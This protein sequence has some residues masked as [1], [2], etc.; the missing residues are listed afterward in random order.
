[1]G[2]SF[3]PWQSQLGLLSRHRLTW[4]QAPPL[5]TASAYPASFRPASAVAALSGW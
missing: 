1:M 5:Q 3:S 2:A 4:K